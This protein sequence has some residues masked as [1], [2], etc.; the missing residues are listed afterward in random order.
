M[1]R[2]AVLTSGGDAPGMNAAIRS[3]VRVAAAHGVETMGVQQGYAGLIAGA[4]TPMTVRSVGGIIG[5]GGTVLGS[6]RCPEFR[7]E[8]GRRQAIAQMQAHGIEG[9]VVIGGGGS[10][11]GNLMLHRMGF[12]VAGVASTIDND[13]YGF[14]QTLGV[15]TALNT[16]LESL[17]RIRST[18]SSHHRAF[19]VEVMG[20]DC[21]YLAL[22]TA[23][24]GGAEQVVVPEVETNPDEVARELRQAYERGKSHAI[25]VVAEGARYNAER[26]AAHFREHLDQL[27][28]ELR[29]TVLGHVQRGGTPTAFD[30]MLGTLS[31]AMA[32]ELLLSGR[33]GYI[34]G[35]LAGKVQALPLE[36]VVGHKRELD[37]KVL[38]LAEVLA[39]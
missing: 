9:L 36:E 26:M 10:Q 21:G 23:I 16:A 37:P 8:Q 25:V 18:A 27:G 35:W 6:A 1:K 5:M 3:V 30:R 7:T 22:M 2:I 33:Y 15:D 38:Q 29:V 28:F 32:V 11:T 39:Q 4:F 17:D 19:L 13:L 24:A 34:A 12:P 20:R 31:G 14:D